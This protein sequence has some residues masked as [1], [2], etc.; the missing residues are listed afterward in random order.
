[1]SKPVREGVNCT[2][3]RVDDRKAQRKLTLE[4]DYAVL[5]EKTREIS[6]QKK[7]IELVRKWRQEVFVEVRL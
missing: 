2:L 1:V 6:A 4:D 3:Y 5:A 7:L